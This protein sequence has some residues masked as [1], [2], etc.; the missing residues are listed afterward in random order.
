MRKNLLLSTHPRQRA[1]SRPKSH[2]YTKLWGPALNLPHLHKTQLSF[3]AL[4]WDDLQSKERENN[5]CW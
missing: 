4:P 2:L 5:L 1:S 3:S